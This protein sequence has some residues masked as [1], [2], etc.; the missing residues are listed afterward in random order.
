MRQIGWNFSQWEKELDGRKGELRMMEQD[1]WERERQ[2]LIS[3]ANHREDTER[4]WRVI[5]IILNYI[6]ID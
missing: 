3:E 5:I 2:L 6:I 1:L 4:E